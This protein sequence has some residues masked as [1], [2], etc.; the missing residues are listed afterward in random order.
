MLRL[1]RKECMPLSTPYI[2]QQVLNPLIDLCTPEQTHYLYLA[3][4]TLLF[5]HAY[6]TRTTQHDPTSESP[7]TVATLTP[8]FSALDAPPY[9]DTTLIG[10]ATFTEGDLATTFSASYRRALAFPLHRS[11]ALAEACRADVA[12]I[13]SRGKRV[14]ARCLLELKDIL[15]HHDVYYVYSKIWVDDFCVW[16]L[17]HAR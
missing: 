17:A 13:L 14:V 2:C 6:E 4:L 3:L 16:T 15:D 9:G 7:W 1:P 5:S 8:L 12:G 10:P 11:F